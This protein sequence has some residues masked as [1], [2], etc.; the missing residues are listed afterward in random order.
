MR[1]EKCENHQK[2]RSK[3][4]EIRDFWLY[5]CDIKMIL[6]RKLKNFTIMTNENY[7]Y[8]GWKMNGFAASITKSELQDGTHVFKIIA[9]DKAGNP[10]VITRN[11]IIDKTL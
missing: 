2:K 4:L 3:N 5:L 1:A 6:F 9:T 10:S 8:S 7:T 11:I